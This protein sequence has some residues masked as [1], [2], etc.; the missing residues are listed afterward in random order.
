MT[1]AGK[2]EQGGEILTMDINEVLRRLPHR[3]PFL[4]VDRV[5]E[6]ISGKSIRA[7][8]NGASD[9]V[10]KTNLM[11]LPPAVERAIQDRDAHLRQARVERLRG[12]EHAVTG[13]L[14]NAGSASAALRDAIRAVCETCAWDCGFYCAY[15]ALSGLLRVHE[16]WSRPD[17]D[18]QGL[19][20]R[21][22]RQAFT[23]GAGLL[24]RIYRTGEPQRELIRVLE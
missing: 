17:A 23:P 3:Y 12:L 9:Y 10:L 20:E 5:Q 7:L 19:F 1:E 15:N 11:R 16:A 22:R 4:L 24:G 14:A 8:K 2:P 6:C 21:R 13:S 18:V